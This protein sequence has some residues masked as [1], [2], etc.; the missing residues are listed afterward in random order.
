M[1]DTKTPGVGERQSLDLSSINPLICGGGWN[2]DTAHNVQCAL[3]FLADAIPLSAENG[4]TGVQRHGINIL[5]LSCAA[6]VEVC[7]D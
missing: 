2:G 4:L 6:A 5:L 1:A 7:H 3:E